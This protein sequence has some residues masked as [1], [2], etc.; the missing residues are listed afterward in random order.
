MIALTFRA[1]RLMLEMTESVESKASAD[2]YMVRKRSIDTTGSWI[3]SKMDATYL[4]LRSNRQSLRLGRM[5][6]QPANGRTTSSTLT[7]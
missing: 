7:I 4:L 3:A 1:E 2:V 5:L 6:C